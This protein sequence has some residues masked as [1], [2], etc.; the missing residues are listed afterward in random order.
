MTLRWTPKGWHS[1]ISIVS[2]EDGGIW[3]PHVTVAAICE[4][5]E[6]FLLVREEVN[7]QIVLN[8]PAG[9]LDPGESLQQAVIRETRE[10][11]AYDFTPQNLTG[12]YRFVADQSS[13]HS[14]LRFAFSGTVGQ[15]HDHP[16]DEVILSAE[17]WQLDEIR[18]NLHLLRPPMVL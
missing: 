1:G 7:G 8:Q 2:N 9:H 5:N 15:R 17:W 4:H 14:F 13:S 3:K 11:T 6:R 16:L 12:I 10:E 18:Q